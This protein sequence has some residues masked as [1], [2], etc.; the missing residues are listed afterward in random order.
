MV[1]ALRTEFTREGKDFP[2]KLFLIAHHFVRFVVGT[3][4]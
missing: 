2:G 3:A 1:H 4:F